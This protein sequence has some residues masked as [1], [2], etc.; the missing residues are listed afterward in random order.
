M[1]ENKIEEYL[2]YRVLW[3]NRLLN[4]D[5]ETVACYRNEMVRVMNAMDSDE[6]LEA[7]NQSTIL[8][9]AYCF[10]YRQR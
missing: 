1:M 8:D 7:I 9:K 6:V 4:G 3:W 2:G 5:F 10:Y